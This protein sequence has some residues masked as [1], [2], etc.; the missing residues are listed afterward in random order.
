MRSRPS[1]VR[2]RNEGFAD[3]RC[4]ACS[5]TSR[6]VI[7]HAVT[8]RIRCSAPPPVGHSYHDRTDWWNYIVSVPAPRIVV[9]AGRGRAARPR[10]VRRRRARAHP[11]GARLRRLC[12]QRHGA[13]SRRRPRARISSCFAPASAVSHAFAHIVDFGEPV[14]VGGLAVVD[15][16]HPVRRRAAACC[17]CRRRS[18]TQ[19]P[20]AVDRMHT[21]GGTRHRVL[22]LA[23]V[24]DRR[25][26][27]AREGPRMT[28]MTAIGVVAARVAARWWEARRARGRARRRDG[29]G[30]CRRCRS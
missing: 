18:S 5:R 4:A 9:V 30:A 22:P 1:S 11:A 12:H 27:H 3:G 13:R 14:E 23:A 7:G 21:Q 25:P 26:A 2:L 15:R 6:A 20:D 24:L 8:A 28:R 10:R 29:D 19:I 17:R 16:R